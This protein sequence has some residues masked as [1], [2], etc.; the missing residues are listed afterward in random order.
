MRKAEP[1]TW[2]SAGCLPPTGSVRWYGHARGLP[3]HETGREGLGLDVLPRDAA[4][5]QVDGPATLLGHGE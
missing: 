1:V 3:H 5:Q 4:Y 2:W